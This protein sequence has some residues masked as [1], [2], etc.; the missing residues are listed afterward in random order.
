MNTKYTI[1][2]KG[3]T[4]NIPVTVAYGENSQLRS[5]D[6]GGQDISAEALQ[7]CYRNIPF[8]EN[9]LGEIGYIALVEAVPQDLSFSAF[10]EAYAY[11]VGDKIRAQKLWTALPD[12]DRVKCLRSI[13]KY[14]QFLA[15]KPHMDRLYP[16]TYLKQRRFEN[17]FKI[18]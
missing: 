7:F 17:S 14:N 4:Q 10:W 9:N 16:E 11:K 8:Q 18:T 2:F 15:Q 6:F 13:P 5:V 1:T 12:E 3:K